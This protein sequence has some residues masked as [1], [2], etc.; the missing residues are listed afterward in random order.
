VRRYVPDLASLAAP[1]IHTPWKLAGAQR[2]Q[3]GYPD[4]LIDVAR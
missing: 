2:S 4:P 1:Y 3:L